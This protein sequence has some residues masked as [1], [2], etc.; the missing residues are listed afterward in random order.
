[1][2]NV[3]TAAAECGEPSRP[4]QLIRKPVG[5]TEMKR[6]TVDRIR[7]TTIER[8]RPIELN[9][10]DLHRFTFVRESAR[11]LDVPAGHPAAIGTEVLRDEKMSHAASGFTNGR[12]S[13]MFAMR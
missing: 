12:F 6:L 4:S 2:Q 7:L 3:D 1:M 10:R 5:L 13:R 11:E 8:V 9:S